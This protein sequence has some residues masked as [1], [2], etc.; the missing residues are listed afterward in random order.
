LSS[1]KDGYREVKVANP[2]LF[3]WTNQSF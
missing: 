1:A 2:Y 3:T